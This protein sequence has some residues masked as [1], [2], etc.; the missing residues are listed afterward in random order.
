MIEIVGKFGDRI[1]FFLWRFYSQGN[2]KHGQLRVTRVGVG[3][4]GLRIEEKI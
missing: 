1:T 3:V 4:R 2:K